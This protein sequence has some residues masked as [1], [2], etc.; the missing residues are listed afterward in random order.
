MYLVQILLSTTTYKRRQRRR[1]LRNESERKKKNK[2]RERNN[3]ETFC[4]KSFFY[5][6]LWHREHF[7]SLHF[8]LS[9][10]ALAKKKDTYTLPFVRFFRAMFYSALHCSVFKNLAGVDLR[11]KV[12]Q[13]CQIEFIHFLV[14]FHRVAQKIKLNK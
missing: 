12:V 11:H 5:L 4:T 7:P 3:F 13:K 1:R 2:A 9:K 14:P 8:E 6:A 10:I